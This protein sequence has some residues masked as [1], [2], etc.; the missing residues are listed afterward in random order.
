MIHLIESVEG[1]VSLRTCRAVWLK[2]TFV[3][4]YSQSI[5]GQ[6]CDSLRRITWKEVLNGW[7]LEYS[8]HSYVL[9]REEGCAATQAL[10]LLSYLHSP[11]F[12]GIETPRAEFTKVYA[13]RPSFQGINPG[14]FYQ[15]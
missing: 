2:L 11:S 5:F 9:S 4:T 13:R 10:R 7:S 14:I 15:F 12:H 3:S 1:L 8:V 6:H